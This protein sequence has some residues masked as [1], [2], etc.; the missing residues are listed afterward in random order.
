MHRTQSGGEEGRGTHAQ[1]NMHDVLHVT[2]VD[3]RLQTGVLM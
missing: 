2:I 1:I 3:C